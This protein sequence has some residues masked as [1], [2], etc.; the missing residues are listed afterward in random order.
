MASERLRSL[1]RVTFLAAGVFAAASVLPSPVIKSGPTANP[2]AQHCAAGFAAPVPAGCAANGATGP[3]SG[4]PRPPAFGAYLSSGPL[5]VLRIRGFSDWLDHTEVRVGHTYLPGDKWSNIEG[6][7]GFLGNWAQWRRAK[8]D[9]ILVVNVPL[10]ERDEGHVP[11][12]EVQQVLRRGAAGEFDQHFRTL[13]EHLVGLG[14]PDTVLVLGWEMNGVTY[15]HRCGPDPDAWKTYWRRIVTVMRSVPGQHFA[16]D[17]APDRG[18]D[19]VPWPQCYPGDDVVDVIGMDSYDQPAG[20]SFDQQVSEP[21]GLQDQVDFAKAHK[22]PISYPEWGLFRNGDNATYMLRMLAWIDEHKPL[23]N[24]ITDY[25]PHGVWLCPA[26][27]RASALYRAALS[28]RRGPDQDPNPPV[29]AAPEPAN[30]PHPLPNPLP[31]RAS[32]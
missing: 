32:G 24:T 28:G 6:T 14:V 29:P 15:T 11:D 26:N 3:S 25:C 1:R 12:T 16:F 30:E 22:K 19:A 31:A 8:D 10:T 27:P 21:Y 9:R 17:F 18:A 13:A 4:E 23:Y 20:I 2:A 5:G 7:P